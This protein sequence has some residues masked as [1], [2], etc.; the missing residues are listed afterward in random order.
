MFWENYIFLTCLLKEAK[1][2]LED[3]SRVTT[4]FDSVAT[5][6]LISE[7][8][9]PVPSARVSWCAATSILL[10]CAALAFGEETEQQPVAVL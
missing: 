6:E 5:E 1:E 8:H 3:K 2:R 10:E 4:L 7:L 9:G